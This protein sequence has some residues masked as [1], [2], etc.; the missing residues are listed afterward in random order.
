MGNRSTGNR[1]R[2]MMDMNKYPR[3]YHFSFSPGVQND[4]KM[5][6]DVSVF[7]GKNI[8]VTE[9]LD[10]ENTGMTS[11]TCHARSLDSR[12]H[13]SRHWVKALHGQ[14]QRDIPEGWQIFGENM[15]AEHSI[16]YEDLTSFL[17]VFLIVDENKMCFS[18]EKTKEWAEMFGLQV[19]PELY[20]GFWDEDAVQACYTGESKYGQDQEGYVVRNSDEFLLSEFQQNVAKCVRYNHVRTGEFWMKHWKPNKLGQ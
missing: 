3:T 9:K 1:Y 16:R 10:G 11:K 7:H 8:V 15:F 4:D 20:T 18:W 14:I 2:P 5:L 6:P 19:V 17:Y 13:S 12:D